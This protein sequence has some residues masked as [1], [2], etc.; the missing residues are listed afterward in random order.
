MT[1]VAL[2]TLGLV[3]LSERTTLAYIDPGSGSLIYQAILAAVLG[4][5]FTFRR[6]LGALRRVRRHPEAPTAPPTAAPRDEPQRKV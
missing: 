1:S 2:G 4:L 5:G 6:M 3:L